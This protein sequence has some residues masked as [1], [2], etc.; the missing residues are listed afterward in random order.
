LALSLAGLACPLFAQ[1][2]AAATRLRL[3]YYADSRNMRQ[4]KFALAQAYA[5]L[6]IQLDYVLQPSARALLDS[7]NGR[8]DGELVRWEGLTELAPHLQKVDV[9]IY[10]FRTRLFVAAGSRPVP[11]LAQARQ[12]GAV[13]LVRGVRLPELL[14]AGWNN[15]QTVSNFSSGLRM[16]LAGRVDA[17]L[18]AE[19]AASEAIAQEGLREDE[20]SSRVVDERYLF[21]YLHERHAALIPALTEEL[22]KL[23]SSHPTVL[24][25]LAANPNIKLPK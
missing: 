7:E 12:L 25:G 9:P 23:K 21:H 11:T 6:G 18:A 13:V 22:L 24:E 2:P 20:F 19:G 16:L 14:A 17:F 5:R 1:G 10:L 8:L 4:T 3:P 15:T